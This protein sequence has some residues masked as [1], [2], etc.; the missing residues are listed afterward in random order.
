MNEITAAALAVGPRFLKGTA[1]FHYKFVTR[2]IEGSQVGIRGC[3]GMRAPVHREFCEHLQTSFFSFLSS[4]HLCSLIQ[5]HG[6]ASDLVVDRDRGGDRNFSS[7]GHGVTSENRERSALG[8][9]RQIP[10]FS[11]SIVIYISIDSIYLDSLTVSSEHLH[12]AQAQ[13]ALD[14]D[15]LQEDE[16]A[17]QGSGTHEGLRDTLLCDIDSFDYRLIRF[18][19]TRS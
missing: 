6:S 9:V 3:A 13:A 1:L 16:L 14:A 5:I 10:S 17:H 8:I 19:L 18:A 7:H 15:E 11:I 12:F 2:G 4:P